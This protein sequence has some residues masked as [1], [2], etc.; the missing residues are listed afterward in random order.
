MEHTHCLLNLELG[1]QNRSSLTLEE[2]S[3]IPFA[4]QKGGLWAGAEEAGRLE[5]A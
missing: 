3:G 4:T 2:I 5:W 1:P